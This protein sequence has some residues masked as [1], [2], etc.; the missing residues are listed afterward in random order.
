MNT[1]SALRSSSGLNPFSSTGY[2]FSRA[3][4]ITSSRR[5]PHD[6][7]PGG[8]GGGAGT[9]VDGA[10]SGGDHD[11]DRRFGVPRGH[12]R[13]LDPGGELLVG[14]VERDVEGLGRFPEPPPGA[15]EKNR[16]PPV[17]PNR[18][19]HAR[20][21]EKPLVQGGEKTV[22]LRAEHSIHVYQGRHGHKSPLLSREERPG[23]KLEMNAEQAQQ[24]LRARKFL[25]LHQGPRT[26]LLPNAW[27]VASA[28]VF[29]A[30]GFP[31]VATT[32]A[33]I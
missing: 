28:R 4:S 17:G 2:P 30:A 24:A 12:E 15:F 25:E 14:H 20:P 27:D 19:V 22:F 1:S 5:R 23:G 8:P 26:L 10:D 11:A 13:L 29:G 7:H 32:S 21:E 33:G 16:P 18:L 3:R 31:A 9:I 6:R